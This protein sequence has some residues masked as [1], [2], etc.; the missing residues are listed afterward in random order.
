MLGR[1]FLDK[2]QVDQLLQAVP[3]RRERVMLIEALNHQLI[4]H[5]VPKTALVVVR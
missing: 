3:D 5:W 4:C 2:Q 1:A